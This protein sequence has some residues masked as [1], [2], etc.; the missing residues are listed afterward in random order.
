MLRRSLAS[1]SNSALCKPRVLVLA[2]PTG[3]GK[4]EV[5]IR[6]AEMV[7]GEIVSADSVQVYRGMDVGVSHLSLAL[8]GYAM[9]V[10]VSDMMYFSISN[11]HFSSVFLRHT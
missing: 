7:G 3:V 6:V 5:S 9:S 4:T 1:A 10:V 11:T 8:T 2:G